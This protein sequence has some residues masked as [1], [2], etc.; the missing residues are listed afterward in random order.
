MKK[1]LC[2]IV[3]AI[4]VL[5]SAR[6]Q[7]YKLEGNEIKIGQPVLFEAG[8]SVLKPESDA[9]L[10]IIK[11]YLDDKSYISLLRVE[12]HMDNSGNVAENQSLTE[13]RAY[14]VCR[15]LIA[16][17]VDCK[18]LIAVGFGDIKP[19][20]DNTTPEGKQV[21]RRICFVNAALRGHPIGGLPVDGGGVSAGDICT[22]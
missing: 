8:T 11:K 7:D 12:A 10:K 19:V 20:E 2:C 22:Q 6:A 18:R 9:A 3:C 5:I 21:N 4:F 1:N 16:L 17:G 13:K 15:A 14:A